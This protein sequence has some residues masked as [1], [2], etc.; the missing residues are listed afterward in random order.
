MVKLTAAKCPSCGAAIE[1]NKKL[2]NVICQYCGSTV[3]VEDAIAKIKV[4]HSGTVKVKGIKDSEDLLIEA[5]KEYKIGKY[6]DCV[7][8]C[9]NALKKDKFLTKAHLLRLNAYYENTINKKNNFIFDIKFASE[10]SLKLLKKMCDSYKSYIDCIKANDEKNELDKE[11][12]S[13]FKDMI[14][15]YDE[16]EDVGD[17][18]NILKF[19]IDNICNPVWNRNKKILLDGLRK[20]ISDKINNPYLSFI[21][22][23]DG[24]LYVGYLGD[25]GGVS[26]IV[27][28]KEYKDI[29]ELSGAL[30]AIYKECKNYDEVKKNLVTKCNNYLDRRY[31]KFFKFRFYKLKSKMNLRINYKMFTYFDSI[32]ENMVRYTDNHYDSWNSAYPKVNIDILELDKYV[33]EL[34][35]KSLYHKC[36]RFIEKIKKKVGLK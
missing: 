19:N 31:S 22:P 35:E 24:K 3:L 33:D 13:F 10:Y 34:M 28:E 20:A 26:N 25:T 15:L 9:N 6:L 7:E 8:S 30:E 18:N 23:M 16:Y 36:K 5:R 1:V 21:Y 14:D 4:E 32:D 2:E 12:E 29:K 11:Q 27:V 17:W